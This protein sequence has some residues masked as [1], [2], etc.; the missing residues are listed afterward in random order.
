MVR[1]RSDTSK[2]S[3]IKALSLRLLGDMRRGD[4]CNGMAL[5]A[6]REWDFPS[7]SFVEKRTISIFQLCSAGRARVRSP[8]SACR[9]YKF[10]ECFGRAAVAHIWHPSWPSLG[11]GPTRYLVT[12]EVAVLVEGPAA[13]HQGSTKIQNQRRGKQWDQT[14]Q[15]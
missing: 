4:A 2:S 11:F 10:D 1:F 13:F 9:V 6:D 5:D 14:E 12:C 8:M 15:N 7:L 3:T